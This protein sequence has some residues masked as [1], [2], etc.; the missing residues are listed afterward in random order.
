MK[1]LLFSLL[2][3]STFA[4]SDALIVKMTNNY[5][6]QLTVEWREDCRNV[7]YMHTTVL[8]PGQHVEISECYNAWNNINSIVS[9]VG[10]NA[11]QIGENYGFLTMTCIGDGLIPQCILKGS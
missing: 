3:V 6:R 4:F 9:D 2:F 11:Q 10:E 5:P 7:Q 8:A 1:K